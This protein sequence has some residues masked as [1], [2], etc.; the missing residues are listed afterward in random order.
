MGFLITWLTTTIATGVAVWLVPGIDAVGDQWIGAA[1]MALMLA[2]VNAT[3][4]PVA[5]LLSMPISVLTLGIFYLIVNAL[6][7]ELSSWL[8]LNVFGSGVYV[9]GLGAAILGSIVISLVSSIVGSVLE[10]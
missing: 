6:L 1:L 7:L 10:Q 9:N 8:S 5:Q 3:I 4:K 2:L